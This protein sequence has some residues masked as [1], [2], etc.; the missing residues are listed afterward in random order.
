[1]FSRYLVGRSDLTCWL[2]GY[3]RL[4]CP[5]E[6]QDWG[7]CCRGLSWM[8][9]PQYLKIMYQLVVWIV[10]SGC[11]NVAAAQHH[12]SERKIGT[13]VNVSVGPFTIPVVVEV[14]VTATWSK[15]TLALLLVRSC[16]VV[17]AFQSAKIVGSVS[18]VCSPTNATQVSS[19]LDS[20]TSVYPHK[21]TRSTRSHLG[22]HYSSYTVHLIAAMGRLS[23][24][25]CWSGTVL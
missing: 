21:C 20:D 8:F 10:H 6:I 19:N 7:D 16:T 14:F 3:V 13:L 22:C 18:G 25:E 12:G 4:R 15:L 5:L 1:M 11:A 2:S 23:D 9:H 17:C 24:H